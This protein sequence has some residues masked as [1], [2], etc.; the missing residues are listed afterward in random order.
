MEHAYLIP[1]LIFCWRI[2]FGAGA[3]L[4]IVY[5]AEIYFLFTQT[6]LL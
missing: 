6:T 4:Y 2:V 3:K 1:N 5:F